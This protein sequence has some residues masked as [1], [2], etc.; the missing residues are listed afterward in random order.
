VEAL[1][2]LLTEFFLSGGPNRRVVRDVEADQMPEDAGEFVGHGGD[3]FGCTQ[4]CFPAAE[5]IAQIILG[6][7][8]ALGGQAQGQGRP[9]FDITGFD[10]DDVST[11]DAVVR[12]EAQPG[13]EAF[14]GG[15]SPDKVRAQ[16]GEENQS[17]V[18][19]ETGNLSEVNAAEAIQFDAGI[20]GRLVALGF[21]VLESG[22]RQGGEVG[23]G[24]KSGQ[25]LLDLVVALGDEVLVVAPS[26]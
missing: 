16:F 22:R 19:L 15:K 21:F 7:P 17:G 2:F 25:A 10:G 13:G 24:V 20:E 5:A 3:S 23:P 14:G 4:S 1:D 18:D 6:S 26:G 12:T 11:S 9:T 8:E